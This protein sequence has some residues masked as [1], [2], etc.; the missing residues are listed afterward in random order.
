MALGPNQTCQITELN[1]VLR[2]NDQLHT[3]DTFKGAKQNK[4][5]NQQTKRHSMP[6]A[7]FHILIVL[8]VILLPGTPVQLYLYG[9]VLIDFASELQGTPQTCRSL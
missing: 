2:P 9:C 4:N 1:V 7:Q 3:N 6:L 5:A 8:L